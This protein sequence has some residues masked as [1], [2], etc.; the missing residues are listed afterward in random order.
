[1]PQTAVQRIFRAAGKAVLKAYTHNVQKL[2]AE[3]IEALDEAR[4]K[5]LSFIHTI[6]GPRPG[7]TKDLMLAA[8]EH[9]HL[10]KDYTELEMMAK[11]LSDIALTLHR[12]SQHRNRSRPATIQEAIMLCD[13]F[14]HHG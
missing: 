2:T 6:T 12:L 9:V 5:L 4:A 8:L 7:Q 3:D 13:H 14:K 11:D 1:M 10:G